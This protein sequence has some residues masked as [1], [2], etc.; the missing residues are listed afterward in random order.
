MVE[1][2]RDRVGRGHHCYSWLC[3]ALVFKLQSQ[4]AFCLLQ[5]KLEDPGWADEA[6]VPQW[7][8]AWVLWHGGNSCGEV[9][10]TS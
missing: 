3:L 1:A 10:V 9:E 4:L 6:A 8:L 5:L 2:G 7:H